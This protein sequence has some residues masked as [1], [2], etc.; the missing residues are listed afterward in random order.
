VVCRLP[1]RLA[2]PLVW[3]AA[4]LWLALGVRT[5]LPEFGWAHYW[6]SLSSL[7][8]M[9]VFTSVVRTNRGAGPSTAFSTD[10]ASGGMSWPAW[11][12]V[13]RKTD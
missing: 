7:A 10:L 4:A 2:V 5:R 13:A 3:V 11:P 9:G 6:V 12:S 8:M 1:A